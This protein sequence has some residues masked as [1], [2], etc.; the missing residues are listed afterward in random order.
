MSLDTVAAAI[1][2]MEGSELSNSI[3]AHMVSTYGLWDVGHLVYAGQ[4]GAV[5]VFIRDRE[6][7]GWPTRDESY[8]GLLRDLMAKANRGMT[9]RQA[10]A[11]FAPSFENDT[12]QYQAN[13]E[14]WTGY[15][16]DTPL[17]DVVYGTAGTPGALPGG[18]YPGET[19]AGLSNTATLALLAGAGLLLLA[20][21]A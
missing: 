17:I 3:N 11:M 15:P 6:W 13:V 14:A 5:P 4:S 19:D 2:R 10:I 8:Q 16:L 9:I 20:L 7:A 12:A 18:L 1:I 21:S